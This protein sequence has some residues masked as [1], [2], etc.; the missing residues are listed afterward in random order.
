MRQ[1]GLVFLL[2]GVLAGCSKKPSGTY[3]VPDATASAATPQEEADALWAQRSDKAKLKEALALYEKVYQSD[4]RNRGVAGRLVRGWYFLGDTHE[5]DD[6]AK[7]AAW[8]T[9]ISW[10]KKCLAIN[11]QFAA[12]VASGKSEEESAG[13]LGADDVPCMY[14]SASSL[15]KWARLKGIATLLKH[16]GTAYAYISRVTELSPG[17]FYGAADRYWGAYYAALPSFAGQDLNKSAEHFDKSG[18]RSPE[19]LGTKVLKAEI[20]AVKTQNSAAFDSLLSEVLAADA[21][22]TPEIEPENKA[23]QARARELQGMKGDL[24]AN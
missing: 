24:F 2:V 18:Q 9:A 8:D 1:L 4:P 6:A 5:A 22:A 12:A 16:K 20:W 10:G 17:Y 11:E 7:E 15:G 23:A 21:S 13:L 14:W 19:Y 3:D